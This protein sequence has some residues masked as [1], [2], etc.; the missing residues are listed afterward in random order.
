MTQDP[1]RF[2]KKAKRL[3]IEVYNTDAER[4]LYPVITENDVYVVWFCKTLQHWKA[5]VSTTVPLDSSYFE[6]THNGDKDETYV[7]M[8]FKHS[9]TTVTKV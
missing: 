9:H 7:D 2:L 1:D 5:L 6:I 4:S 8:Y 3:A